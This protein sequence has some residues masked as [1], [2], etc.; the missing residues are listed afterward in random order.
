MLWGTA[1]SVL[2]FSL[3]SITV[4]ETFSFPPTLFTAV[5]STLFFL[6]NF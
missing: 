3:H 2:L 5:I 1:A 6:G 4:P